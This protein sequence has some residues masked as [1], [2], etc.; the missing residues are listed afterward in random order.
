MATNKHIFVWFL[1]TCAMQEREDILNCHFEP[2]NLY[3]LGVQALQQQG[4]CPF[5]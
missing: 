5:R 2:V 3:L 4:R 1:L